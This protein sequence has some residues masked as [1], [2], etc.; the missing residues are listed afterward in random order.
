MARESVELRKRDSVLEQLDELQQDIRRRAYELF[1]AHEGQ[2]IGPLEDWL[3]AER[4]LVWRPPVEL[5]QKD[6]EFRLEAALAGVA[7]KDLDIQ[8]TPEDILIS[9][10]TQHE[11]GPEAGTIHVCEFKRG[12][13]FRSIHLPEPIDPESIKAEYRDGLLR[14]TAQAAGAKPKKVDVQAA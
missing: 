8:V 10:N 7:L 3:S 14:L 11:H 9:C 5:R 6:G 12:R 1:K 4:E 13:L 2:L